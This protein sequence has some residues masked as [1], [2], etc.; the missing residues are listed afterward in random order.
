MEL[1]SIKQI[2][3]AIEATYRAQTV[4]T[5]N[6]MADDALDLNISLLALRA[7]R[8]LVDEPSREMWA[9]GGN[10]QMQFEGRPVHHDL[11]SETVFKAMRDQLLRKAGE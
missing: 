3:E 1:P 10:S 9:A 11:M 5:R 8:L 6:A 4:L 7:L 2:D